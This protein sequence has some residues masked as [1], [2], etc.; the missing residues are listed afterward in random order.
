MKYARRIK[1]I[2]NIHKVFIEKVEQ[3]DNDQSG[4]R[5]YGSKNLKGGVHFDV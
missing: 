5:Q 2:E 4:R 1:M 3:A